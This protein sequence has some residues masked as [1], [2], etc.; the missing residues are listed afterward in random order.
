[1]ASY[2][3]DE[4]NGPGG[5][6]AYRVRELGRSVADLVRW[7]SDVDQKMAAR[8]EREK[9]LTQEMDAL[10]QSVDALRRTLLGF[11]ITVAASC[12]VFALTVYMSSRGKG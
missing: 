1:M 3:D 6:F 9:N 4:T 8:D 12:V 7:R 10:K 2:V 5:V 11:A